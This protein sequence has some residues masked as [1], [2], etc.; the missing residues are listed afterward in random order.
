MDDER[1]L[2]GQTTIY[3]A[4]PH[5]RT[6]DPE[7]SHA[8]AASLSD[9]HT[10]LRTLLLTFAAH[11]SLTA[12]QACALAGYSPADGAWKRVSD[13]TR[14]GWVSPTGDATEGSSGRRQRLLEITEEGRD[15]LA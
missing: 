12:E 4:L 15:Q 10:M 8:A 13:L 3:D 9:K 6:S 2:A 14:L 7:T 1:P 5:A 11:H